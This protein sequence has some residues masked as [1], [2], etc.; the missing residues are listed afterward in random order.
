MIIIIVVGQSLQGVELPEYGLLEADK[1]VPTTMLHAGVI[2][3]ARGSEMPNWKPTK[4]VPSPTPTIGCAA[5]ARNSP[6][7]LVMPY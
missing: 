7:I 1:Y 6:G 3:E 2:T 5:V 4:L